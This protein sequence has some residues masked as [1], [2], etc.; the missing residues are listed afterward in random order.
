MYLV[1]INIRTHF[2]KFLY[3]QLMISCLLM[4]G[5]FPDVSAQDYFQ[6]EVNYQIYVNLNDNRH[7]LNAFQVIEYINNSPDTLH[8]L[9]FHLWP[10]AYSDNATELARELFC[11]KGR[12]KLFDDPELEGFI[13]S[14]DF[15]IDDRQVQWTLVPDFPDICRLRLNLPLKSGDT[16]IISTPFRVKIPKGV[17]SRLGHIDQSYQISQWYPK[18]A[19]YDKDGWHQMPY[20]DQGEF[21]SEFGNYNVH[22]TLPANYIVGSTGTL[23][24]V[25]EKE[26][27]DKLAADTTWMSRLD[28]EFAW[29]PPSSE[30]IKTL[31]F[32]GSRI[33]D[34][35][36]FADKRFHV[37]KG[38]VNLPNSGREV[39]TWLMFTNQQAKLWMSALDY[40]N[41]SILYFSKLIGDYPYN[42]FTAI[43][44]VV[45]AG[46]GMEYPGLAVISRTKDAYSLDEVLAH[47]ICHNWFYS[48]LGSNE[49][50]YPFMDEGITSA[51]E[52]RYMA[53][54]YPEKKFWEV[55][56][57]NR[58]LAAFFNIDEI[59]V[60]RIWEMEWL[61]QA[62][63]NLEQPLNLASTD[64][65]ELNSGI[66][67]Y[68]KSSLGFNYLRAYLGDSIFDCVMQ[69]YYRKWKFRHPQPEDLQKVF[70]T[71]TGKDL[72][73]FFKDFLGTNKRLDY[74][75]AGIKDKQLLV[76][77]MGELISPFV[78]AGMNKD[79]IIFEKWVEGFKG[80][81][82]V[83]IPGGNIT[84]IKIDPQ[85][86]M[87][88]IN[89]LNNDIRTR[90]IFPKATY[91]HTQFYF[92]I[93]DPGRRSLMYIPL[94]NWTR[95]NGIMPGLALHNGSL[96]PKPLEFFLMPFYSLKNPGLAGLGRMVFN[97]TPYESY[98]RMITITLE[99]TQFGA[100]GNLNFQKVKLGADINFRPAY[101]NIPLKQKVY[102]H[103]IAA[104]DL[105]E[106]EIAEKARLSSYLQLGYLMEMTR[107]I[108]P[109][110]LE[111]FFET[112]RSY[113][114]AS[115]EFNYR[116]S[117]YGKNNGLDMRFFAGAMINN[118]SDVPFY[119]FSSSGRSGREQYL[120]E[121][122][123]PDRFS[124]F[125]ENFWSRQ[126]DLSEG[127]LV[128][129]VNDSIGYNS[130]LITSSFTG[131]LPGMAGRIPV[132]PFIN[133]LLNDHAPGSPFYYEAG[134]KA[135]V[136]N[137]FEIYFPF[138]VSGKIKSY[139]PT[140]NERIRFILKLD[141]INKVKLNPG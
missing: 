43:Q 99:G 27:M 89:R 113:H 18:P 64:Y 130:W 131:N 13:D 123:Y 55:Y 32:T 91:V 31:H 23:Q 24:S 63:S 121:G 85:H 80:N 45:N 81:K 136:W 109:Y 133:F 49:R 128:S 97:I 108:N 15:K 57:I 68:N 79:S 120:Y 98:V 58:K 105:Y 50:R 60:Q 26:Q 78:I 101:M 125:P 42:T 47:E 95:E 132:K 126:M 111:A 83:K 59:P 25:Y 11:L 70:E 7:E 22:I 17:T 6:Q 119:A 90:G 141:L 66:M 129:P 36:W 76:K 65:N 112:N 53:E 86:V 117:Y 3:L 52:V 14:L 56:F 139:N 67:V 30:Q 40:V 107:S 33:H 2:Q 137:F 48:A 16:I 19:V 38:K 69:E 44:S 39:T 4:N 110:N 104:T 12:Q 28:F 138:F 29:F 20:L 37:I 72:S 62:R 51:Y 103:Y 5:F 135:G 75:L 127:G 100:P 46:A 87:P 93:E 1:W 21:Y 73:W 140:L 114:K 35:A 54:R 61:I 122:F 88:E 8:F 124:V 71:E 94:V 10:N 102:S 82:W 115:L 9:Y 41:S 96:I 77:N 92:T 34:F 134:L 106:I 118:T 84:G 74:K 116:C